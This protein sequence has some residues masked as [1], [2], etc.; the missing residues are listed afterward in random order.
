MSSRRAVAARGA[1]TIGAMHDDRELRRGAHH[2]GDRPS[3]CCRSSTRAGVAAR[4]RGRADARPPRAVR[5]RAPLGSAVGHDVVPLHGRRCRRRGPGRRVEALIDLGFRA[6]SPGFQCEGLVRDAKGVPVQGIHPRRQ[7]VAVP[8][9]PGPVELVVEAASNPILVQFRPSPLGSP[10][11][12][13][14]EP[15]YRLDRAELVVVDA[16]AEALLHDLDVLDGV[17]RT[18]A[19]DDPRRARIRVAIVRALDVLAAPAG[20]LRRRGRRG[21]APPSADALAVPARS[22]AHRVVATGHA[23]I[24]TAWLWPLGETVRKC[25]RTFASA[26]ALMD[27][28]PGLPLLV[29]AGPAVRVDRGARAGA[30]RPHRRQGR[31]RAVDPGRRDVGRARHEPAVGRVDRPPDRVRAAV[32]RAAVRRALPRGVDPRRVRLPGR[33]AAGVRRRRDGP[34]R[35]PEA[36]V[37]PPE[38]L[39]ALDVLVGGHRRHPGADPLPARRH[40]QRRDRAGGDGPRRCAAS[41]S[42]RGASGR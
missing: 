34:L 2:A 23:H 38:P 42:T 10:A 36:V 26:V 20:R 9:E 22:G 37:E 16:D 19:L 40:L 6:D 13:G 32:L 7:A 8:S 28:A 5:R 11:T 1:V 33:A 24:D 30:V 17:M 25:T 18:L 4:R 12:A 21:A 27:E 39:P 29:L 31:R 15:L 41:P 35:H 3:A 14:T